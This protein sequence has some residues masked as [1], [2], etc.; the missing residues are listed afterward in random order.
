MTDDIITISAGAP[1]SDLTP[2]VYEVTLVDI[3][4]P[5]TI[6]P[7]TG[8]N[9]GKE[10]QLRDWT[11][12]LEDG[13]EVTGSAS[14]ASGP[15][16]QDL[17]LADGAARRH[18]ARGGQSLPEVPAPRPRG[19]GDDHDRRGRLGQDHQPLGP[20][21]GAP[22]PHRSR[23]QPPR[24][25]S[26]S[27]KTSSPSSRDARSGVGR[28][29]RD[30]ADRPGLRRVRPPGGR[31]GPG[32]G[33][34]LQER[35]DAPGLDPAAARGPGRRELRPRLASGPPRAR[36]RVRPRR[37]RRGGPPLARP[38]ARPGRGA[39]APPRHEDH[40]APPRAAATPSTAGRPTCRSPRATSCSASPS[41]GRDAATSSGP[42]AGSAT[43]STPRAR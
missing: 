23:L 24:P 36:R 3:S 16:S 27:S 41:A 7:Q 12:A 6:F 30:R 22:R 43:A 29:R 4:E 40:D 15:K 9:A 32:H 11:F 38:D 19:A 2:G 39:R 21:D 17:R 26:R 5:R 18:P 14:T 42:A 34:R 13:T 35:D 8:P 28:D 20:P 33:A 25:P 1:A 31:E 10:V 37:R